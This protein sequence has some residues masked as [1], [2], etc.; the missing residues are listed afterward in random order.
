MH[1]LKHL[2][3]ELKQCV[4]ECGN[5]RD[6]CLSMAANHCLEKGGDHVAPDHYRLMLD[7]SEI[8]AT[9]ANFMLR[10]SP[11]HELTCGICAEICEQCADDCERVGDMEE[12]VKAC[13]SCAKSC[14]RMSGARRAA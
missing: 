14:R 11:R 7:C 6:V 4:E 9:C 8:C 12:C 1:H 2:S 10:N 3:E 13:R 5:C